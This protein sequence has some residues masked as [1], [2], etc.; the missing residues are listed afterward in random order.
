MTIIKTEGLT[1]VFRRMKKE[2]GFRGTLK[3]LV[4]RNVVEKTALDHFSLEIQEGEC[5]G[6]IGPNGA[7]PVRTS[8]LRPYS[9]YSHPIFY[10]YIRDR[11]MASGYWRCCNF[12]VIGA[13]NV[14][15]GIK[16]LWQRKQLSLQHNPYSSARLV[17]AFKLALII[18]LS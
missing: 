10:R 13:F 6:L 12:Y 2:E 9:H 18:E 17:K 8:P 4:K 11:S 7:G 16:V 14:E 15:V 1:K 3:A 5:V